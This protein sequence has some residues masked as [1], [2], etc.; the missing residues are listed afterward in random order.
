MRQERRR[1]G[2]EVRI[3]NPFTQARKQQEK[4]RKKKAKRARKTVRQKERRDTKRKEQITFGT[5]RKRGRKQGFKASAATKLK[6]SQI[7][8][9][10]VARRQAERVAAEPK[11]CSLARASNPPRL[12][13]F[14]VSDR[15]AG[16]DPK[17]SSPSTASTL[18]TT[19]S[20]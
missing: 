15:S 1:L 3:D 18:K 4:A 20:S 19:L 11:P 8:K 12:C 5:Y 10:R 14:K 2:W 17:Q 16:N 7:V 13:K 9:A 6:M